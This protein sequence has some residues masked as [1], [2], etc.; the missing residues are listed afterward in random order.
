MDTASNYAN[1]VT[2]ILKDTGVYLIQSYD[3]FDLKTT[4]APNQITSLFPMVKFVEER[5]T[6]LFEQ[7]RNDFYFIGRN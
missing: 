1:Q 6:R 3:N 2:R 5:N 7:E 4:W